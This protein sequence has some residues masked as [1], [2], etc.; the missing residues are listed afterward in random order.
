MDPRVDPMVMDKSWMYSDRTKPYYRDGVD[1]FIKFATHTYEQDI[2]SG[3]RK[4]YN[5][6][7]VKFLC[8][9]VKCLNVYVHKARNVK[10]HLC[11]YGFIRN[12]AVWTE[13]GEG[14]ESSWWTPLDVNG[15]DGPHSDEPAHAAETTRMVNALAGEKYSKESEKMQRILDDAQKPLYEGCEDFT[16]ISAM[17]NLFNL[18]SKHGASDKFFNEL[19]PLIQSML[20]PG[21]EMMKST[22]EAKK[23][24]R[25]L[26]SGYEKIH[27]CINDCI[28]YRKNYKDAVKC[29]TC[30]ESRWKVDDITQEVHEKIPAK[31]LWYFPIIPR[32]K[33]LFQSKRIVEY[34]LWHSVRNIEEG[35]LKHPADSPAWKNIDKRYPEIRDDPRNLRLGISADGVDVNKGMQKQHSVWPI[36]TVI[37]NLPPELCMKRKFTMLSLIIDGG[38]CNDIDVMLEPFVEDLKELFEGVECF[39][40]MK[41]E[42]FTLRAVVLWTIN[43]YPALGTLCGCRY[44]GGYACKVCG[45][46]T[47][48]VRL[49]HCRKSVYTGHRR[50]LPYKHAF[51]SQKG[52]NGKE[53]HEMAPEPMNPTEIYNEVKSIENKWGK[54]PKN[55]VVEFVQDN[56]GRGGKMKRIEKTIEPVKDKSK[57]KETVK[58]YWKKF[59]IWFRLLPYWRYHVVHH[60]I[61]FMHVEK[62]VCESIVGTLLN[63]EFKSKDHLAAR[64]DLKEMG[65]REEL[66][67]RE[68]GKGGYTLKAAC[69][70][71]SQ[72]EKKMFCETLSQIKVPQGYCSNFST[73]VN[74][75]DKKLIGLKSHDY[76]ILMQHF[77]PIA[78][79]SIMPQ[80]TRY[81]IIRFCFFFRAISSKEIKVAELEKL[82]SELVVT[83]CLLEKYF[84]P[85]FFDIMVHLTVHLTREVQMC[86]PVFFRWMYPFERCMK[87]IKGHVRNRNKPGGSIAEGNIAE[88]TIEVIY[89][90]QQSMNDTVGIPADRFNTSDTGE[91]S[92]HFMGKPISKAKF[93]LVDKELFDKAHFYVLQN[94]PEV[95][96]YIE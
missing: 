88:E 43:D 78:I 11:I 89:E 58:R 92:Y 1:A 54:G 48:S 91:D 71:L 77:L 23:V 8:P 67:P 26:G 70:T 76:H 96:P 62:N 17:C 85:S 40:A 90:H 38:P 33:R 16:K 95:E 82:Q 66:Q 42:M 12:Y 35:V 64:M 45:R 47:Y 28:L 59:N 50:Y 14:K 20:P 34:L 2:A 32:L 69:H 30:G 79:K 55:I 18:K 4:P 3:K 5:E 72:D 86:G 10:L 7:K 25:D 15:S 36:L 57:E 27:V 60:C 6:G 75:K 9:C 94:S 68:N 41:Q 53:E 87:V 65:F 21:N 44:Q 93:P 37:Y 80:P 29:P 39:D 13:H 84:P 56:P 46:N 63:S 74:R 19:L 83:L 73:L 51:R 49:K 31:V 81:A 52:F 61:D 22:Y 24:M